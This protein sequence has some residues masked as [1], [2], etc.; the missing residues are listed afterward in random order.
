MTMNFIL[1]LLASSM[2]TPD[3]YTG[4]ETSWFHYLS[5]LLS[6]ICFI[7]IENI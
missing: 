1:N 6:I 4:L 3:A 5:L 7:I 2:K